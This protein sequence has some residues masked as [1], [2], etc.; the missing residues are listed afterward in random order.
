MGINSV[1]KGLNKSVRRDPVRARGPADGY[2]NKRYKTSAQAGP[3]HSY[4]KITADKLQTMSR[5]A[6]HHKH[7]AHRK[8]EL[9]AT[10]LIKHVS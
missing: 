10:V 7:Q 8:Q 2:H 1:F 4:T 9:R 6:K 5:R 3:L